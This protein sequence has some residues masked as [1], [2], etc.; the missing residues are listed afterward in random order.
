M[1]LKQEWSVSCLCPSTDKRSREL[2]IL[3]V[4]FDADL[5]IGAVLLVMLVMLAIIIDEPFLRQRS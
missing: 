5:R 3:K 2:E 1:C 4:S